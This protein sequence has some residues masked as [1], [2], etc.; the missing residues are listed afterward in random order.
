MSDIYFAIYEV[1]EGGEKRRVYT[2]QEE[3]AAYELVNFIWRHDT[4][5]P[6]LVVE[7]VKRASRLYVPYQE[8]K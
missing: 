6:K 2:F 7:E 1:M 8:A 5:K 3:Q 4:V